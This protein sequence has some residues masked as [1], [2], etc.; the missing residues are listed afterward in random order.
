M[1]TKTDLYPHW[2][3][4]AELDRGH[5]RDAGIRAEI[6]PVSSTLRLLARQERRTRRCWTES[7]F[8]ELVDFL[9]RRVVALSDELDRRSTSQ[10]VLAVA[11]QLGA[12]MKCRARRAGGPASGWTRW[13]REL[14]RA[15]AR[16][17]E[18]KQRS[19]RWQITLNDGVADLQS[20]IEY[21]LRDRLRVDQ[22]RGRAADRR[23]RPGG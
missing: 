16:A 17:D 21:D 4:I 11:E 1:L 10:D 9:L 23:R 18:L 15:K 7:G 22:P 2:R 12:G 19:S 6:F 20:D 5:L 3:R 8:P 13:S 14:T